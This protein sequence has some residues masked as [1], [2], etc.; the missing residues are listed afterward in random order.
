MKRFV[1]AV[2][3]LF[4]TLLMAFPSASAF[5]ASSAGLGTPA[6]PTSGK[7]L[8]VFWVNEEGASATASSPESFE[9][10][11]AAV[12]YV[13]KN[14]GG[15]KGR[16]LSLIHCATLG[17][18]T[19]AITCANDAVDAKPDVYIKGVETANAPAVPIITG[20]GIPYVTLNAGDPD[21]LTTKDTFSLSAGYAAQ[22][23]PVIPYLKSKGIK[24][25]GVIYTN[26]PSLSSIL[27]QGSSTQKLAAKDK[28]KYT[29]VP[30]AIT[31]GDLT[32]AYSAL[33]A[34]K[35]GAIYVVTDAQQCA[36]A[37]A[38]RSSLDDTTPLFVAS[39][40]NV[41]SV[42]ST[43]PESVTAGMIVA[44]QDTS[45]VTSDPDTRIYLKAMKLYEPAANIGGF[46]PTGFESIIDFYRAMLTAPD[47]R[48]LDPASIIST[49]DSAKNV[50]LFMGGGKTF[51]CDHEAFPTSPSVCTGAAFLAKYSYGK[52]SLVGAYDS[53]QL[54]KGL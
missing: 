19:S 38:A 28:I 23:A 39:A 25:I 26:V 17:T 7:P 40:C 4:A 24:S 13:N 14:L 20:A 2:G 36:A 42:L 45:T 1:V 15:V 11:E 46:A 50:P 53:S 10:A 48:K 8:T 12:D 51:T 30:A 21:E 35:V 22:L 32:P 16:P 33:L 47:P 41:Q 29:S 43:V 3:V 44:L 49:L 37:L 6:K 27:G 54:L 5:G 52:Y 31:T 34:D 9:A 18:Q